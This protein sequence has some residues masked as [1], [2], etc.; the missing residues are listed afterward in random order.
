MNAT[1]RRWPLVCSALALT[2]FLAACDSDE[3]RAEKHYQS[4]VELLAAEDFDRAIVELRNV[5]Q[6]NPRHQDAR[7]DYGQFLKEQGRT[8]EAYQQF[9]AL[10]EIAPNDLTAR[11]EL[12]EL[13]IQL[14][15]FED[16]MRHGRKAIEI[17]AEQP[18]VQVISAAIDYQ[19]ALE[20]KDEAARRDAAAKIVNV[21]SELDDTLLADQIEVDNL[22]RNGEYR[23]ALALLDKLINEFPDAENYHQLKLRILGTLQDEDGIQEQ[24]LLLVRTFPENPNH[25]ITYLR[26]L[27]SRGDLVAAEEFVRSR[28]PEEGD[29][30]EERTDLVNFIRQSRGLEAALE[31]VDAMI[32]AGSNSS[33]IRALRAALVFDLGD[34]EA[35]VAE[36]EEVVSSS[37]EGGQ[38]NDLKVGLARMHSQLGNEVAARQRIE[39]V[40]ASDATHVEAIKVRAAWLI[41]DDKADL[42]IVQIRGAFDQAPDDPQL[43]S[44]MAQAHFRNGDRGLAGEMLALAVE[45]SGS[46][47]AYALDYSRY[48]L[49][50]NDLATAETVLIDSLRVAPN[51]FNVLS[52]LGR[53]YLSQEDWARAEQVEGTL[54]RLETEQGTSAAEGLRVARL[55]GQNRSGEALSVLQGMAEGGDG[56]NQAAIS[57]VRTRVAAGEFDEAKDFLNERLAEKPDDLVLKLAL[58]AV[59]MLSR[60]P[61]KAEELY[62]AMLADNPGVPNIWR[63]LY[64]AK[65]SQGDLDAASKVLADG[66][67]ANPDDPNLLWDFASE[68]ER[69]GDIDS[70]IDVYEALYERLSGSPIVANNLASLIAT[71]RDDDESLERAYTI[72]RRLRGIEVPAFQ[73]TYGWIAFRRGEFEEAVEHLEPAAAGLEQDPI[74]Q[75]HFG[76]AL[77]AVE[78]YEEAVAQLRKAID[79]AGPADS[80]PQFDQARSEIDRIEALLAET[81]EN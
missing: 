48:L 41:E 25:G 17:D 30:V 47:P 81:S 58:A 34:R 54:R 46:A 57:I 70:A 23:E 43:M 8:R 16:L 79:V 4:A 35:A 39:E 38:T 12:S 42:A 71:Y 80:R 36:L 50:N 6:L 15:S 45:A 75:F 24:L 72:A 78:R 65:I 11:V 7:R 55:Q 9:L 63:S 13:A 26:W 44:I 69:A 64:R 74:V 37:E 18:R 66:L 56:A 76:R 5:F 32:A 2:L 77:A 29:G 68:R 19:V 1:S 59:H 67:E 14:G 53:V 28:I 31:E 52:Q 73:D 61:D 22:I 60:Q 51:E 33:V 3:D 21:R 20:G 49:S 62:L 10:S 27:T 40:L